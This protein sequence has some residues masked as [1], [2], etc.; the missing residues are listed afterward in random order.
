[1]TFSRMADCDAWSVLVVDAVA[2]GGRCQSA[3]T[4]QAAFLMNRTRQIGIKKHRL[5]S[6]AAGVSEM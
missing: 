1:M 5:P 3:K 6:P 4:A 2:I